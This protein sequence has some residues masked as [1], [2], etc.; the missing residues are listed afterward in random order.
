MVLWLLYPLEELLFVKLPYR[1][2]PSCS[3]KCSAFTSNALKYFHV[4][5]SLKLFEGINIYIMLLN[6]Y[7]KNLSPRA[8]QQIKEKLM[9]FEKSFIYE[10]YYHIYFLPNQA[11]VLVHPQD[12]YAAEIVLNILVLYWHNSSCQ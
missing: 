2:T 12:S 5:G 9:Y 6:I 11:G 3:D 8:R 7:F 10:N 1:S 4:V